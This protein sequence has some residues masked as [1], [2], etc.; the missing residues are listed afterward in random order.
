MN[1]CAHG[2]GPRWAHEGL[3]GDHVDGVETP[4]LI[5][6]PDE[7]PV[8]VRVEPLHLKADLVRLRPAR[9]RVLRAS[10]PEATA[11]D[12]VG[13]VVAVRA[14]RDAV[15]LTGGVQGPALVEHHPHRRWARAAGPL[16]AER[17]LRRRR[18]HEGVCIDA[19]VAADRLEHGARLFDAAEA[20]DFVVVDELGH[21]GLHLDGLEGEHGRYVARLVEG[22]LVLRQEEASLVCARA[23][24]AAYRHDERVDHVLGSRLR[25]GVCRHSRRPEPH[26]DD[27]GRD[28]LEETPGSH[29]SLSI[30]L[31]G[32]AGRLDAG[33]QDSGHD[34]PDSR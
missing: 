34:L 6:G 30:R 17:R 19:N 23:G 14:T 27:L 15:D 21:H 5:F 28:D 16:T 26:P 9:L 13:D 2:H 10:V 4:G 8:L 20:S 1:R 24:L 7:D 22:P 11:E 25:V 3:E 12:R 33:G 18:E 32:W 31:Q 29:L